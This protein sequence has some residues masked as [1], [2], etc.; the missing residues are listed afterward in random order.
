MNGSVISGVSCC[1]GA[2]CSAPSTSMASAACSSRSSVGKY[3]VSVSD[4]SRGSKGARNRRR[5]SK[6]TP[7]KNGCCLISLAPARPRRD[8]ELQT[9]L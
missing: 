2:A 6:S 7:E 8:S 4:V 5:L 1:S 9:R 3:A